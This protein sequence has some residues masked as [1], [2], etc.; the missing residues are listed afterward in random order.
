MCVFFIR[1]KRSLC[2]SV[3]VRQSPCVALEED[4]LILM[5]A[6]RTQTNHKDGDGE[7]D[8]GKSQTIRFARPALI[9][10][11]NKEFHIVYSH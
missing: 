1:R 11:E 4:P 5:F 9:W 3:P 7:T 10:L 6:G 8:G 2:G